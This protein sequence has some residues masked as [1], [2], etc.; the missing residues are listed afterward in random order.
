MK[1]SI[2]KAPGRQDELL[3]FIQIK[4]QS[5][6]SGYHWRVSA[7]KSQKV[8]C[9]LEEKA[10]SERGK[11]LN[12]F[13]LIKRFDHFCQNSSLKLAPFSWYFPNIL[14]LTEMCL[15]KCTLQLFDASPIKISK[16]FKV[17]HEMLKGRR[18]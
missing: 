5:Q 10:F 8:I 17:L 3:F 2:L 4:A 13:K 18:R 7:E 15:T 16:S 1:G 6:I 9:Y 12:L 11:E 14:K